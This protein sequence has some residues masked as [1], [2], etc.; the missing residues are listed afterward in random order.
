MRK[1]PI[2]L[3]LALACSSST[4]SAYVVSG[5]PR[6]KQLAWLH[7]MTT[8]FI[9]TTPGDLSRSQVQQS[10]LLLDA[11]SHLEQP[12]PEFALQAETLLKRVV[13]ERR[14]GNMDAELNVLDYNC[15]LEGWARSGSGVAGAER[16][17]SILMEMQAHPA[18]QPNLASFKTV[19]MAWRKA[20]ELQDSTTYYSCVRAQQLL[21]YMVDLYT[22]GQNRLACPDA[23]CFDSVLQSWTRSDH[24]EAP[25]R[26]EQ[27]LGAMEAL[28]EATKQPKLKPRTTSFNAVLNSWSKQGNVPRALQL[29]AFME[30]LAA[31]GK[32]P[33]PDMVSYSTVITGLAKHVHGARHAELILK[34]VEE[35]YKNGNRALEPDTILYNSVIAAWGK[36][37]QQG[38]YRRARSILSRQMTLFD[39]KGGS[40]RPDVYGFTSVLSCCANERKEPQKAFQV[41]L[42]TFQQL[43]HSDEYG[44]P[45]H[46]TYG[47]MLKC[48]ARLVAPDDPM[49]Q[50]WVKKV[51]QSCVA[52]GCVGDMVLS[53]L[54]EATDGDLYREL[55]NGVDKKNLPLEWTRNVHEK[56]DVRKKNS[57]R[58]TAEV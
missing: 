49:R 13:D 41:A 29:L 12:N 40:F 17:D 34:R 43:R 20:A 51:F 1:C 19:I 48:C 10:H 8:T 5:L 7:E 42:A 26:A 38:A 11:W 55:L 37:F 9:E 47:A 14:A 52:D 18:I 24:S 45:N 58:R 36:S 39:Q 50:K 4:S 57:N 23:D 22:T 6:H 25:V 31:A 30:Q 15:L 54:R 3:V 35:G 53:R 2:A 56:R 32:T 27:L 28:Y 44:S 21:E 16:C 33:V 46:V